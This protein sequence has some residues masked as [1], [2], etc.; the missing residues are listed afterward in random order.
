M[1]YK[2]KSKTTGDL[3]M[4]EANGRRI[5]EIIGKIPDAKGILL[6][7]HMPSAIARLEAAIAQ[8][9]ADRNA[10]SA[11]PEG[12]KGDADTALSLRQ[13]ARPFIDMLKRCRDDG[14]DIVWGV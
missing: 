8:E 14:S 9:Q 4:L 6:A 11:S 5:L 10:A 7:A 3:I 1:L 2:F 13:R 12:V